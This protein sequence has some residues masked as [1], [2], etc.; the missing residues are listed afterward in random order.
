MKL[1]M[2]CRLQW[3]RALG[4]GGVVA[5]FVCILA[6]WLG[7]RGTVF[8][9]QQIPFM[10]S[11]G[12]GGLALITVGVASWLSAD[13]RDEWRKINDLNDTLRG[14]T[15]PEYGPEPVQP[16]VP[17]PVALAEVARARGHAR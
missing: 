3:D 14:V 2:L 8:A 10:I 6:A 13:L 16:A 11:G 15:R 4:L 5:G 12:I 17:P 9:F 1:V 7:A